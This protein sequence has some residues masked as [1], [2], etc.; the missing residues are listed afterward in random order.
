MMHLHLADRVGD[1]AVNEARNNV[2]AEELS[3]SPQPNA[4]LRVPSAPQTML[5]ATQFR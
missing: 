3:K 2:Q 5:A 1:F 4:F